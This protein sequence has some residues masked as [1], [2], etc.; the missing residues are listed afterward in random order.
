[1][2]Q[3]IDLEFQESGLI[4]LEFQA[5]IPGPG[6]QS[7]YT[8]D[9]SLALATWTIPHNLNRFPSVSVVD[10]LGNKVEPDIQWIDANIIQVTHG[11]AYAGKAYLN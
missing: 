7:T 8:W 6:T 4:E 2:S 1:M 11:A 3:T 5:V 10:T 9:Q